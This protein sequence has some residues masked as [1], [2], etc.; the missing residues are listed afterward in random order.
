[1]QEVLICDNY[2]KNLFFSYMSKEI[3]YNAIKFNKNHQHQQANKKWVESMWRMCEI[4]IHKADRCK[5][6]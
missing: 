1:M 3:E 4:Q 5:I 6:I 2:K